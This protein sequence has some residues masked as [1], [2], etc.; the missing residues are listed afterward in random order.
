MS[1]FYYHCF[2]ECN[3]TL[4]IKVE[5]AT[6]E[7]ISLL[8]NEDKVKI[9]IQKQVESVI[10]NMSNVIN[11]PDSELEILLNVELNKAEQE[12][13]KFYVIISSTYI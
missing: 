8:D 5:D 3:P 6:D 10:M 4:D 2:Q 1:V 11:L 9:T 7:I 13:V 12:M